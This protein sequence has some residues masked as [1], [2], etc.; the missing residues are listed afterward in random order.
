MLCPC[1]Q[2]ENAPCHAIDKDKAADHHARIGWQVEAD[3]TPTS[4]YAAAINVPDGHEQGMPKGRACRWVYS[5]C[6]N[7]A[8][9]GAGLIPCY[10]TSC[11]T[12]LVHSIQLPYM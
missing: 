8:K 9:L 1:Q 11:V 2:L 10:S 5:S 7:L 4:T 3:I 12:D 6:L